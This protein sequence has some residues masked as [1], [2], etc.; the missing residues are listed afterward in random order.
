MAF[1]DFPVVPPPNYPKFF[2]I[3]DEKNVESVQKRLFEQFHISYEF[4]HTNIDHSRIK[5]EYK[6]NMRNNVNRME[7]VFCEFIVYMNKTID[8]IKEQH[9][10]E[11]ASLASAQVASTPVASKPLF[12]AMVKKPVFKNDEKTV[13]IRSKN[14][15]STGTNLVDF[16]HKNVNVCSLK[17]G[18]RN[19]KLIGQES[20]YLVNCI[21]EDSA[22]TLISEL[23]RSGQFDVSRPRKRNPRILISNIPV[24]MSGDELFFKVKS[25]SKLSDDLLNKTSFCPK[26]RFK[27]KQGDKFS[28]FVVELS[29][30]LRKFFRSQGDVICFEWQSFRLR[31]YFGVKK[32]TNCWSF[33]HTKTYCKQTDPVCGSCG[34]VGH[35]SK[36]CSSNDSSK[37]K[38]INCSKYNGNC[39]SD[40]DKVSETHCAWDP[41]CFAHKHQ[42][43]IEKSKVVDT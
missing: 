6:D 37:F 12:S 39:K 22:G 24:D 33:G 10:K 36:D 2:N 8:F 7:A 31:D 26:F 5:T 14:K 18:I 29:P 4:F 21:D 9:N 35:C 25:Q 30:E 23:N 16:I 32:C 28:P 17:I 40:R 3:N 1:K 43:E 20:C 15:S 41:I 34:D 13:F 38:C 42:V 19:T 27:P 11:I